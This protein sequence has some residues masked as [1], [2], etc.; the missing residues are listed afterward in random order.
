MTTLSSE[1]EE[2]ERNH[3]VSTSDLFKVQGLQLSDLRLTAI[4]TGTSQLPR[5]AAPF[6]SLVSLGVLIQETREPTHQTRV[7]LIASSMI[8]KTRNVGDMP[9]GRG[10]LSSLLFYK[11]KD[12]STT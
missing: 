5:L 4:P 7:L 9:Q 3:P 8:Q 12:R 1:L 10:P 11:R 2:S 6:V